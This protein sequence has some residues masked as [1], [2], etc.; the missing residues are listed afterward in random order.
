RHLERLPPAV[1]GHVLQ[2]DSRESAVFPGRPRFDWVITSPPYYGM[3][4]YIPDQWLRYW[5]LGGPP[6]V[7]YCYEEQLRH[8]G[9]DVFGEQLPAVW[10][11]GGMAC[12]PEARLVVR[13]GGINARR[14][15]PQALLKASLS[16][17]GW[18]VTT[19]RPAGDASSGKRQSKQFAR[20]EKK[21]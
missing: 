1:E 19:S 9:P 14:A 3:R 17:A 21:A 8:T 18:Q 2:A 12:T 13:L 11:N 5:F 15:E 10:H 16:S 4:T 20:E 7:S 6:E